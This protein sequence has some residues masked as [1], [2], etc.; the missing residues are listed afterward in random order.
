MALEVKSGQLSL[1]C[2]DLPVMISS[3]RVIREG[4]GIRFMGKG[5][6][7]VRAII[8]VAWELHV[9]CNGGWC[10]E[11]VSNAN[12]VKLYFDDILLVSIES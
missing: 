8:L 5:V 10:E 6:L 3:E 12:G 9:A 11:I 7:G 4:G 1:T 2:V